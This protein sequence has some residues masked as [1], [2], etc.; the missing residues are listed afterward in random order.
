[1]YIYIY[2]HFIYWATLVCVCVYKKLA[3]VVESNPKAPF[4]I[5]TTP[6]CR[7]GYYSFPWIAPL[8][9]DSYLTMLLIKQGGI[10]YHFWVFGTN[11]PGIEP[12]FPGPLTNT[13]PTDSM[14]WYEPCVCV[15]RYIYI[16]IHT[17]T[18]SFKL[19]NNHCVYTLLKQV[20]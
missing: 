2:I 6:R 14:D 12:W 3:T 5:A 10:K 8:T 18:C 13:L 1:M 16:Y 11:Q 15:Y 19:L 17:D 20:L 9:L 4:S 7:K